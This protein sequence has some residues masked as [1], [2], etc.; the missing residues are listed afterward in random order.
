MAGAKDHCL[1][2]HPFTKKPREDREEGRDGINAALL[3]LSALT[4]RDRGD[5]YFK[6][7]L[8]SGRTF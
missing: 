2:P 4:S 8:R 3:D 1:T 5:T 6:E 7:S